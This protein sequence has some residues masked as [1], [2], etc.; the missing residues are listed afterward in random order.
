[1]TRRGRNRLPRPGAAG[2]RSAPPARHVDARTAAWSSRQAWPAHRGSSR[3][4]SRAGDRPWHRGRAGSRRRRGPPPPGEGVAGSAAFTRA[5]GET[6]GGD[7]LPHF[8]RVTIVAPRSRSTDRPGRVAMPTSERMWVGGSVGSHSPGPGD[9]GDAAVSSR[10]DV[11]RGGTP[12]TALRSSRT[13]KS[14]ASTGSFEPD[15]EGPIDV[16]TWAAQHGVATGELERL[17]SPRRVLA[18]EDDGVGSGVERPRSRDSLDQ[19]GP[20]HRPQCSEGW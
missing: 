15:G 17:G 16:E 9:L 3:W 7:V 11:D 10:N 18:G 14:S 20:I 6:L 19:V 5:D 2:G 13:S 1:M 12:T 8:E 4:R